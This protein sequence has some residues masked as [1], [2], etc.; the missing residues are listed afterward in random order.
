MAPRV[1]TH[2]NYYHA[3]PTSYVIKPAGEKASVRNAGAAA[4]FVWIAE[5]LPKLVALCRQEVRMSY[6]NVPFPFDAQLHIGLQIRARNPRHCP[7]SLNRRSMRNTQ[8]TQESRS[9]Y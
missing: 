4:D 5:R 6:A 3:L 1:F 8:R 2:Y 7:S 9:W